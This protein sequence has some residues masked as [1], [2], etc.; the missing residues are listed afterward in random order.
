MTVRLS[1]DGYISSLS[2]NWGFRFTPDEQV[3]VNDWVDWIGD[4]PEYDL[5]EFDPTL[6]SVKGL[7]I[8]PTEAAN[9]FKER[10]QAYMAQR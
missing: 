2:L 8:S 6:D 4:N 5:T 7:T 1:D 9:R 3:I 10:T